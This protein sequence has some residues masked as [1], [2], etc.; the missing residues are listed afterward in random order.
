MKKKLPKTNYFHPFPTKAVHRRVLG[1]LLFSFLFL[2]ASFAQLN[3]TLQSVNPL[4]GG[5]SSG[6]ITASASGGP[7]PYSYLWS[8][9]MNTNPINFLPVG[10]Y[11][12]TVT[13]ANG[14]TGTATATLTA[15]PPLVVVLTVNTCAVPGSITANVTG[16]VPPYMYM[17]SNGGSTPTINNLPPGEYCI[18][19]MDANNCGYVTC[20]W[21]GTPITVLVTT[22]SHI[23][24]GTAGGTATAVVSGGAGPFDYDWSNGETTETIDTLAPGTYTVTV[25]ATNGCTATAAGTVS[26][27]NGNFA[28]NI[29]VSQPTCFGS[30]TGFATAQPVGGMAPFTYAWSNGGTSQTIQNLAAGTYTVTVTDAFGCTATK[31]TTLIYQSNIQLTLTPTNPNCASNSNGSITSNVSG[32]IAPYSYAWSNGA[33]TP[34]L[35]NLPA[36]NYSLTVTDALGCTKSA[37]TTLTAPPAFTVTTTVTNATFCGATN[38]SV[39]ATPTGAGPFTYAWSNGGTTQTLNNLGAGTYTVTVTNAASC[40]ATAAATVTQPMTLDVSITGTNIVCG[41]DNNGT[42]TANVTYGTAPYTFAWSNGG[43]TQTITGLAAGTYTVTVTSSQGCIGTATKTITGSPTINLNLAVQ[44]VACNGAS[45]G[46]IASTVSGGTA[47]FTYLWSNGATTSS[48]SNLP[49][50][51]YSL[52]VTDNLGCTKSQSVT[53]NQPPALALTFSNSPGSCGANGTSTANVTGGTAPYSYLW[54]TGATTPNILNLAP[55]SYSVTV[56]DANNCTLTGNTVIIAYPLMNLNVTATNTT[57]N[58]TMNGTATANVTNGTAPLSYLWS[59]G[60]TT[61]TI[62]NLPPGTYAVTVTD[63][64]GC[65]KTGSATVQ[66]GAGLVVNVSAPAYVCTGSTASA[67][68]NA[69]GGNGS[70]TYLWSNGQTTQTATGLTAGTY[71]VTVTDSQGCFGSAS[72]TLQQ[73]GLF[74][75]NGTVQHVTCFNGNNGSVT[76]NVTGGIAPYIYGWSNG[77]SNANIGGLVAGNYTVTVSDATGCSK[78]QTFT[79]NQPTQL[80]ANVAVTNGTCGNQGS[81]T[82]SV[83]GGTSPYTYLWSNGQTTQTINNLPGGNYSLTVT[84]AN[85]C[86]AVKTFSVTVTEPPSCTVVLTQP[87]TTLNGS[88]GQLTVN[89]TAGTPPYT[90]LWSNGQTTQTAVNLGPGLY[91]VTVTDASGCTTSCSFT[92]YA[93]AKLGDF[94]WIDTDEDGIQDAGEIGIGGVPVTVSGTTIYGNN[95]TATAATDPTGMYMFVVQPGSYKLTFGIPNGYLLSPQNQGGNDA[96]DS[97]VNPLTN[98]TTFYTLAS[99]EINPTI[100]AGFHVGPPCDNVTYPGT[101]CCDQTL[102]GPGNIPAPLTGVNPPTGGSGALEYIW[103]YHN[104]PGPFNSN[105]TAIPS[106]T[107]PNYAPGPLYETTYFIRCVR[108]ENCID[109][110]ESNIVTIIVDDDAVA[111]IAAIDVACVGDPINFSSQDN[112]P[113]ASYAWNFGDGLPATANTQNVTGVVWNTWGLKTVTLTV[114]ANGCT[115][116]DVHQISITNSPTYCGNAIIIDAEN[117]G[118]TSVMVDWLYPMALAHDANFKVEWSW[119][120]GPFETIGGPQEETELSG[121]MHFKTMH[122]DAKRGMNQYRV[123]FDG[124]DQSVAWSNTVDVQVTGNYHF[125]LVWPNP[126][127]EELNVEILDRYTAKQ[128]T[129]ELFSTDGRRITQVVMPDDDLSVT[130]PT[131]GLVQG[132]YFLVIKFDGKVQRTESVLKQW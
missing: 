114:T 131:D 34:N 7:A 98:M 105:W 66:L 71:T 91:S 61:A 56:T 118:P 36:G 11:T 124:P 9:G 77:S 22:T 37:S 111:A 52:I 5:F 75:I 65:T 14:T 45:T 129:C 60:G 73:G 1:A 121:Y 55:G 24:G 31:N 110:L 88:D 116:T 132:L 6:S 3:V 4:C 40:T 112:G 126:F 79:I 76:L 12:V 50:G 84:D 32:G 70:Y 92:L 127:K 44:H 107:G 96:L 67:T 81:A 101:I 104:Q 25:T 35:Q 16:G 58:G 82:A 59:N 33:N 117:M 17:W 18:T 30:N 108:R 48:I 74:T 86:T 125:A 68:A 13:A 106:A 39:T 100:D 8:N 83:T 10:T 41:S 47:P 64:N 38:G 49:A 89:A 119:N 29:S 115:S 122:R 21:V 27:A 87:I 46:S 78:T 99:G 69:T 63:G 62:S 54:S 57:C 19:V 51:T 26:L 93:P 72:V 123:R 94:T 130:I 90:Y 113:G 102:C 15:P 53:V 103:M 80:V 23:C 20:E 42:L 85:N 95:Y 43:N 109:F 120:G 28:V 97:D 2:S 128:V